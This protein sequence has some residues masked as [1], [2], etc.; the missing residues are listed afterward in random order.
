VFDAA[1]EFKE[2]SLNHRLLKGE[3]PHVNLVGVLLRLREF[4]VTLCG[5]ITKMFHQV[6]V[7]KEDASIYL[8]LYA[9]RGQAEP[10][11]CR[12]KVHIMMKVLCVHQR[13]APMF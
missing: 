8:F 10:D 4:R 2:A 12:M 7:R 1:A 9:Q 5:D 11:V 6:L 3:V 13:C